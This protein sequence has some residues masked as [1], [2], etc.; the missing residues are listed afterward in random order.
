MF[1]LEIVI[2][3]IEQRMTLFQNIKPYANTVEESNLKQWSGEYFKNAASAVIT[4][5]LAK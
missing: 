3:Q 5:H 1:P 2:E 4:M